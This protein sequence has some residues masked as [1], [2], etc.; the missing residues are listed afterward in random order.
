VAATS[1]SAAVAREQPVARSQFAWG[2]VDQAIASVTTFA[3]TLA[4]ARGTGPAGVGALAIAWAALLVVLGAQRALLVEPFLTR[5]SSSQVSDERALGGSLVLSVAAGLA[6]TVVFAVLGAVGS[7]SASAGFEAFAPWVAPVLAQNLLRTAAF[8]WAS[9][10][11]AAT[12][13][14]VF[15]ATFGVLAL[16]GLHGSV[17]SLV[18]AWGIGA[19]VSMVW[20]FF[21]G[22]RPRWLGPQAAARWWRSEALRFGGYLVA[23][24]IATSIFAY[25]LL[26]GL[27]AISGA[28]AVGGY[29]VIE[30]VFSPLSLL[31][32]ALANPGIRAMRDSWRVRPG[33]ALSLAW[34]ISAVAVLCMV[35][36]AVVVGSA[37]DLVF[38]LFGE[39]FSA[40]SDLIVPVALAQTLI[41]AAIGPETLLRAA[42]RG[43][44]V[45]IVGAGGPALA[46]VI[47]LPLAALAGFTA[48][49]WGIA[50]AF[51]PPLVWAVVASRLAVRE[52]SRA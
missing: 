32:V 34:K 50:L 38:R 37:Q 44:A 45:M 23:G 48:A 11:V 20:L 42:R 12:G 27:A 5:S 7:E 29:R 36:Y 3:L 17:R 10:A 49:V 2:F 21:A 47:G 31:A 43:R 40:Y 18:A 26:G 14:A 24:V 25:A 6:G 35:V 46:C 22:K 30:S 13:S 9:G 16:G 19:A 1:R 41:A 52:G 28:S 33:A 4:V 8:R 51:V 15:L 39:E